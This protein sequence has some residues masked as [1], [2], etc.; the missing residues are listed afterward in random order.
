MYELC[1]GFMYF[2]SFVLLVLFGRLSS[3]RLPCLV[4]SG[5]VR[6]LHIGAIVKGYV[7]T[8]IGPRMPLS[9]ACTRLSPMLLFL[10]NANPFFGWALSFVQHSTSSDISPGPMMLPGCSENPPG[11]FR[12]SRSETKNG[13]EFQFHISR[14]QSRLIIQTS[15]GNTVKRMVFPFILLCCG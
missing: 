10:S 15:L 2:S 3:F 5:R 8:W 4:S 1:V 12:L 14:T 6:D 7:T 11:S 9:L 13:N